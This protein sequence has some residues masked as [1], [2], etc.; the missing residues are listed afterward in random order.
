MGRP[1]P[2]QNCPFPW[3]HL[4]SGP[5]SNTWFLGLT[6]VLNLNGIL[7]GAVVFAHMTVKCPYTLQ[8]DALSS[9]KLSLPMGIWTPSNI[10][11]PGASRV[12]NPNGNLI[13]SG[14]FAGLTSV[15]HRPTDRPSYS[16]SNKRPHACMQY[17]NAA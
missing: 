10:W 16:V 17:C 7:I 9:Q 11:F 3:G 4:D 2:P 6:R 5:P 13:G 14:V 1:F 8:W 12:L 15:T